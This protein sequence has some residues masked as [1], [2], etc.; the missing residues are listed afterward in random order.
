MTNHSY[1]RV[2][3][4]SDYIEGGAFLVGLTHELILDAFDVVQRYLNHRFLKVE[5]CE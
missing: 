2:E 5:C 3:R 4:H 1:L